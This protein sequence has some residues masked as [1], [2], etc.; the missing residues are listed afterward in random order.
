MH[1]RKP[2]RPQKIDLI[3]KPPGCGEV[4]RLCVYCYVEGKRVVLDQEQQFD[5]DFCKH[6]QRHKSTLEAKKK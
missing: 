2:G 5:Y 1:K 6:C 3:E 4:K